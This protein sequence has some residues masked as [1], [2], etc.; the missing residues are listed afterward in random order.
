MHGRQRAEEALTEAV[1]TSTATCISYEPSAARDAA[2]RRNIEI[3]SPFSAVGRGSLVLAYQPIASAA[4]RAIISYEALTRLVLPSGEIVS[5][6]PYV[7]AAE[8][9]GMI[10]RLDIGL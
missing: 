6:G 9:L 1:A 3:A 5:G 10:R 8:K 2:R 4:D 7:E